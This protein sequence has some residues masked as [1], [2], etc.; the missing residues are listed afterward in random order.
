[1]H[2]RG[3]WTFPAA[4]PDTPVGPLQ[5]GRRVVIVWLWDATEPGGCRGI[6]DDDTRARAAAETCIRDGSASSARVEQP[7][8]G[9]EATGRPPTTSEQGQCGRLVR[10]AAG[11]RGSHSPP[12]PKY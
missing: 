8:S 12:R 4:P 11:S 7:S 6:T 5:K 9:S 3:A 1:M 10:E 2:G